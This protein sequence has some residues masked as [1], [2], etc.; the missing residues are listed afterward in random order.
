MFSRPAST[1]SVGRRFFTVT[2]L[3][4][5]FV[6]ATRK[7][8]LP[9][10]K[11]TLAYGAGSRHEKTSALGVSHMLRLMAFQNTQEHSAVRISRESE[12]KGT[13]LS[14]TTTREMIGYTANCHAAEVPAALGYLADAMRAAK[15][16]SHELNEQRP[17]MQME[18]D[19]AAANPIAILYEDLH[20][21]SFH[22]GL[23]NSVYAPSFRVKAI[24][25]PELD[26]FVADRYLSSAR[27]LVADGVSHEQTVDFAQAAF[28]NLAAPS[29]STT[30]P[31]RYS[32][33]TMKHTHA[34]GDHTYGIIGFN[35]VPA[36]SKSEPAVRI[37]EAIIDGTA[38]LKWGAP[39]S[40]VYGPS[41]AK[42]EAFSALYSDAGIMGVTVSSEANE[43]GDKIKCVAKQLRDVAMGAITEKQL[44]TGQAKAK[45]QIF[46]VATSAQAMEDTAEQ[47]IMN[48]GKLST[49]GEKAAAIDAVSLDELK[50][51]AKVVLGS[52]R[53]FVTYGNP[54]TVPV[55]ADL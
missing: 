13:H 11:V 29:L 41:G 32:G 3:E 27:C 17:R 47:L 1:A 55:L 31:T 43:F 2:T 23:G 26:D 48:Q 25:K 16:E 14:A 7:N 49:A 30:P 24:S 38:A 50:K 40:P 52:T 53:N 18:L 6:V 34:P 44:R 21:V 37:L 36:A 9:V 10:A 51:V 46:Q 5:G 54:T 42:G 4:N 35:A 19:S 15:N 33:G 22:T 45:L 8:L 12:I 28:G 39:T 20:N